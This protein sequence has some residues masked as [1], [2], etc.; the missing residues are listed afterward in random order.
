MSLVELDRDEELQDATPPGAPPVARRRNRGQYWTRVLHVYISM[1]C[2]LVVLFFSVTG[3]TLNHPEWTFGLDG[4][5]T[6]EQGTLGAGWQTGGEV[7]WLVVADTLRDR[8]DLRG[9]VAERSVN[10]GE[11]AISFKGPGFGADAFITMETGAYEITINRQ[12]LVGVFNDLHK[13]RDST[14]SWR[15]LID[16]SAIL[17]V[18]ISATGLILQLYLRR[19]RRSALW[20]VAGGFVLLAV[21]IWLALR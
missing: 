15:W 7:D 21:F 3:L 10:G 17:L 19:R 8:Y 9:E 18:V 20:T 5:E 14:S 4:S 13:G 12:G 11:A 6:T 16:A 2:L 1:V